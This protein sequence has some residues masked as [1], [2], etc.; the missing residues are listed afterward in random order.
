MQPWVLLS[1]REEENLRVAIW[2]NV[3]KM[4]PEDLLDSGSTQAAGACSEVGLMVCWAEATVSLQRF[5]VG[6]W[7]PRTLSS[8]MPHFRQRTQVSLPH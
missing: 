8:T 2:A 7:A 4:A 1:Q 5:G 6:F 3:H